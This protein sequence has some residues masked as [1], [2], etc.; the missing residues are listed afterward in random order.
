MTDYGG[1]VN[2]AYSNSFYFTN[3]SNND[4][5]IYPETSNQ[6]VHI[7][8]TSNSTSLISVNSN[9]IILNA[10]NLI[11]KGPITTNNNL[12]YAPVDYGVSNLSIPGLITGTI[13]VS[14]SNPFNGTTEG[15]LYLSGTTGNYMTIQAQPVSGSLPDTTIEGWIYLPVSPSNVY[16]GY[17]L[18]ILIGNQNP[19]SQATYWSMGV[20]SSNY[21]TFFNLGLN[22]A[23]APLTPINNN[24][25]YHI[26]VCYSNSPKTMQMFVNGT[27]QTLS[28]WGPNTTG[29]NTTTATF[30][31][32][33]AYNSIAPLTIGQNTNAALNAYITSLRWTNGVV[34]T[35]NF[36]LSNTPLLP[37]AA[38]TTALLLRVPQN[39]GRVLIQ[40]M[41]G[42]TQVQA[43]PPA[44]MTA[45][46]TNIQNTSYG[47]GIYIAS[48]SSSL[49]GYTGPYAL[50]NKGTTDLWVS[51]QQY[52]TSTN[53]YTGSV[54]TIDIFGNLYSGEWL[55]LQLPVS[56]ILTSFSITIQAGTSVNG[57]ATFYLLSSL[58]GINWQSIY[59]K[60][61]QTWSAGGTNTFI[62][63]NSRAYNYY[64]IV[65][66]TVV[67][68]STNVVC[69]QQ[70][71]FYGTQESI[72]ITP[73][74][75][76]GIGVTRPTQQLEVA[77]NAI[78]NGNISANN[79]GM[80][81][82][83]IIN[84]D[85]KI[86]QRGTTF[87]TGQA[88]QYILDRWYYEYNNNMV[89]T[90]S[91]ST[92]VPLGLGLSYSI[93]LTVTTGASASMY[94]GIYQYIEGTNAI[95]FMWGT[96]QGLPVVLSFWTKLSNASNSIVNIEIDYYGGTTYAFYGVYT[97]YNANTWEYKTI[98]IP[99]PPVS[100]G[101][102][103]TANIANK[104]LAIRFMRNGSANTNPVAN[105]TWSTTINGYASG[106]NTNLGNSLTYSYFITG[107]QLEKGTIAT[108]FEFRPYPIELELCQRYYWQ[109]VQTFYVSALSSADPNPRVWMNYP[110]TMRAAPT[111]TGTAA[112]T[113]TAGNITTMGFSCG[114]FGKSAGAFGIINS[115][116]ATAEL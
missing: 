49:G 87:T 38:G 12:T 51:V 104:I 64:R 106:I 14:A 110:V 42:T 30:S 100:S 35:G 52:S 91:Q 21:L 43:Y 27:L 78:I 1:F 65:T 33:I 20:N 31:T 63:N 108:P 103:S 93:N 15:S 83:C 45:N 85:M 59:Q 82:N 57:P 4:M 109:L 77:G 23:A 115:I 88:S 97:I 25:W 95:D 50:F 10:S 90:I 80:F 54:S 13:P 61:G 18:P 73:D 47:A 105:N 114:D 11:I 34:Y 48:A 71:V 72:S 92:D 5:L 44:A 8:I 68:P 81:R 32:G 6:S 2:I 74:G 39:P 96:S 24:T 22:Y 46:F 40:K 7:G 107:V 62:V 58:D 17:N 60:S 112:T 67:G 111:I 76:V 113:F 53:N 99:P 55:Q 19:V 29:S 75:Q 3:A 86:S 36:T 41:G 98:V 89:S 101:A 94:G 70:C 37:A 26:A 56:I 28:T 84:G 79:I 9:T 116:Y 69:F 102:F 66:S 16:S